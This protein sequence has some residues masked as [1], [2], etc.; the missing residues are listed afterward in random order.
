MPP[1]G[2]EVEIGGYR[3]RF[4]AEQCAWLLDGGPR[5][6]RPFSKEGIF[7]ARAWAESSRNIQIRP[8][9]GVSS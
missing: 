1:A 8:D 9:S 2:A 3:F 6:A 7:V 5:L 4:D